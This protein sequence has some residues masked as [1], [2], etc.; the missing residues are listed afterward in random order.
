MRT[1]LL[2]VA[3]LVAAFSPGLA[4]AQQV[5]AATQREFRETGYTI[6]DDAIWTYFAN[7]GGSVTFGAPISRELTLLDSQVQLFENAA[8]QV[9]PDGSVQVMQLP[10]QGLLPFQHLDGLTVPAADPA[11]TFVAPSPDQPNYPAR[12]AAYLNA[13]VAPQVASAYAS[14][15]W[16]L[17]TSTLKAD[18]N[19]PNFVYQRFQNGILMA[20]LGTGSTGAL[21]LGSYFKTVLTG[22]DLPTDLAMEA[23]S[24]PFYKQFAA[25]E[26]F[27]PD[28]S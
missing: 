27:V 6:A 16:G 17:P 18:P 14:D 25:D 19:N 15:I 28:L 23:T 3:M 21:P 13:V 10:N 7:H 11:V 2:V 1:T 26:A 12:L 4:S 20:D 8:L 5:P 22:Q 9:Q 24:L